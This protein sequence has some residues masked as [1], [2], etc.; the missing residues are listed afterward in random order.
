MFKIKARAI[1]EELIVLRVHEILQELLATQISG[2]RF[3]AP[4][5]KPTFR[6]LCKMFKIKARAISEELIVLRVHEILQELLATQILDI[7]RSRQ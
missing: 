5:D 7:L 1:F 2:E 4:T 6:R 3:F